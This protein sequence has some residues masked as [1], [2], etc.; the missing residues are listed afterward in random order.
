MYKNLITSS[1]PANYHLYGYWD[2]RAAGANLTAFTPQGNAFVATYTIN[3]SGTY[4]LN[5]V[6]GPNA[7]PISGSPFAVVITPRTSSLVL[8]RRRICSH[9][10]EWTERRDHPIG[11]SIRGLRTWLADCLGW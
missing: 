5:L 8:P 7:Q 10:N 9:P 4:H 11:R 6:L 3:T 2:K 1:L